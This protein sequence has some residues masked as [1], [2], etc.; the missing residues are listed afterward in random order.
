MSTT[1]KVRS[2]DC[3]S[4]VSKAAGFRTHKPLYD[5]PEN[6]A[7]RAKRPQPSELHPGDE[8]FVPD[9]EDRVE[10]APTTKRTTF[11]VQRERTFVRVRLKGRPRL[12]YRLTTDLETVEGVT[13]GSGD[14]VVEVPRDARK[15]SLLAWIPEQSVHPDQGG[16]AL[17]REIEL[18]CLAPITTLRG[19]QGRLRNLGYDAGQLVEDPDAV[20]DE[21]TAQAILAFQA[22]QGRP[23]TG[24][25]DD[26]RDALK[27]LHDG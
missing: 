5:D 6:Q 13:D 8:I 22:A 25:P 15:A 21:I 2:G 27:R 9:R 14:I 12:A 16:P 1:Y 3:I 24:K 23:E 7:L 18:G 10:D 26:V 17:R 20:C 19:I 4:S 11:V